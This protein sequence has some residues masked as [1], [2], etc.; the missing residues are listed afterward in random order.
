MNA[1]LN[2]HQTGVKAALETLIA[3]YGTWATLRAALGLALRRK[4][5]ER[6]LSPHQL[7]NHLRR[8]L[9]LSQEPAARKYWELR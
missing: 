2:S 4:T 1:V 9:G 6:L 7:S 8:D 3:E 5:A